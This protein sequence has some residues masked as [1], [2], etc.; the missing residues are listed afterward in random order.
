MTRK[1][2]TRLIEKT[3]AKKRTALDR[4]MGEAAKLGKPTTAGLAGGIGLGSIL[5]AA[6]ALARDGDS[7]PS[8]LTNPLLLG[9][10]GATGGYLAG[11]AFDRLPT[12]PDKDY[13]ALSKLSLLGLAAGVGIPGSAIAGEDIAERLRDAKNYYKATT[14]NMLPR[15]DG[16]GLLFDVAAGRVRSGGD[17]TALSRQELEELGTAGREYAKAMRRAGRTEEAS[18]LAREFRTTPPPQADEKGMKLIRRAIEKARFSQYSPYRWAHALNPIKGKKLLD[19]LGRFASKNRTLAGI[20]GGS[21][22]LGSGG[23][24]ANKLL[25]RD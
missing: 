23:L 12:K 16:M 7:N 22:L 11:N 8:I 4:A 17:V 18:I 24:I 5:A 25:N 2:F 10:L 14:V 21:L 6:G 1:T 3:A 13:S 15:K 19:Q 9:A 20:A